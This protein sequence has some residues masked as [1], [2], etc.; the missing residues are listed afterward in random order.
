MISPSGIFSTCCHCAANIAQL[1]AK[2]HMSGNNRTN[3][4]QWPTPTLLPTSMICGSQRHTRMQTPSQTKPQLSAVVA[5]VCK[6]VCMCVCVECVAPSVLSVNQLTTATTT[7]ILYNFQANSCTFRLAYPGLTGRL[8]RWY[9]LSDAPHATRQKLNDSGNKSCQRTGD[10]TSAATA[11][12]A[13]VV[14][15]TLMLLMLLLLPSLATG[16]N[17]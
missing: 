7:I 15:A 10:A 5:C 14:A 13:A 8:P 2:Q 12:A 3:A 9:F 4:Q 6:C 1:R 16:R 11:A 17:V